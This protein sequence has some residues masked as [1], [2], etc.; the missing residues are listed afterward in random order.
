MTN[1]PSISDESS[2]S[3]DSAPSSGEGVRGAWL[4]RR[5][6]GVVWVLIAA[7]ALQSLAALAYAVIGV[8]DLIAGHIEYVGVTVALIVCSLLL[9]WF[10]FA[11]ARG[12]GQQQPWV[13]GPAITLQIFVALIG[14]SCV[15]AAMYPLGVALIVVGIA[16]AALFVFPSV[17]QH[18]SFREPASG[19]D[20]V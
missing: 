2:P 7:L 16:T 3:S 12:V 9:A 17:V 14:I 5:R 19:D 8:V 18:I 20:H 10:V 6:P 15:Q 4:R 11:L 1:T 13:R